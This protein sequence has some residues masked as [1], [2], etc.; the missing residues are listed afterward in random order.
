MLRQRRCMEGLLTGTRGRV[1]YLVP[2]VEVIAV[3]D[4]TAMLLMILLAKH[5]AASEIITL[6]AFPPHLWPRRLQA[7]CICKPRDHG[8]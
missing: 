6:R 7:Q 1:N 4:F 2:V 3:F 5:R 8:I